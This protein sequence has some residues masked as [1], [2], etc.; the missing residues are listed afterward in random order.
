MKITRICL[1]EVNKNEEVSHLNDLMRTWCT[2]MRFSFN[3]LVEGEKSGDVIKIV[4]EKFR[5]NKRYAEDAVLQAQIV[6]TSQIELLPIHIEGVQ[7]KIQKTFRKIDDYQ[8]GKKRPKKISLDICLTG[9]KARLDKLQKKE[10]ELLKHLEQGTIPKVIFGGRKKFYDRMENKISQKK[11]KEIRANTLY[12]RGDKSKKGNLN[13]RIVLDDIENQFYLEIANPLLKKEGK[14]NSPRLRFKVYIPDKY[15]K[16]IVNI[17]M[18]NDFKKTS[19]E[20]VME[21]YQAYSIEIKRKGKKYYV[22]ITYDLETFGCKLKWKDKITSDFVAG[23]DVN[24]DKI[25]VTVL[26][27]Q[28]R[29]LKSRTFYCH[30]MEYVN[31]NRR[32]NIAGETAK[33]VIDYL[34][35][36]NVGAIVLES[37]KFKQD[38]DTDKRFNRL[39]QSFAKNKMQK[40]IISRGLKLGFKIKQV[41]PAYTSVI[42][43]FKYSKMYGLSVHEAASFV[44]GRRG[45]DFEEK[46]PKELVNLLRSLVKPMLIQTLGSMEESEK[47]SKNSKQ[48]RKFIAIMI[49]NIDNFKENHSWKLWNV[50]HKTLL[51][52]NQELQLKEV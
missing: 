39:V 41:N 37:L 1:L 11:W 4:Q 9:L 27:K 32:T 44:I 36:W 12:S 33:E 24:I 16:E 17:I 20:K 34:L 31:S 19:T 46:V 45:L 29:F 42:G 23:I 50:I 49:K 43:R 13:T 22:H 7:A 6:I 25:A 2:A 10:S 3:R 35:Q 28:G 5:L 21:E 52:K 38:H 40:A 15:F 14:K 51:L 30:E 8:T 48:R 47:K 26:N 18:A